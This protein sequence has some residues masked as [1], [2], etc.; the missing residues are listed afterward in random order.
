MFREQRPVAEGNNH[1]KQGQQLI[2][3]MYFQANKYIWGLF[4]RPLRDVITRISESCLFVEFVSLNQTLGFLSVL[5]ERVFT[6]WSGLLEKLRPDFLM[7]SW[8]SLLLNKRDTWPHFLMTSKMHNYQNAKIIEVRSNVFVHYV[9]WAKYY[10]QKYL[11][12]RNKS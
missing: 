7:S 3:F 5:C 9:N 8:F 11:T 1:L 4:G 2:F 10:V 12:Y 6:S